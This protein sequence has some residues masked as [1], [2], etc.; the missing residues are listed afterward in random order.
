MEARRLTEDVE[1]GSSSSDSDDEVL[2][3]TQ[4]SEALQRASRVVLGAAALTALLVSAAIA[5]RQL[6]G[7]QEAQAAFDAASQLV[8][9]KAGGFKRS[10]PWHPKNPLARL[11][12]LHDGNLCEDDE[13]LFEGLCYKKCSLLT[14][15]AENVRLSAFSCGQSRSM[16]DLLKSEVNTFEPCHGYDI[17]G[18]DAG[19]GCPHS[20]GACLTDEEFSLGKCYKKCSL[21]TSGQYPHRTSAETCCKSK[22]LVQCLWPSNSKFSSDFSVGGG[23]GAESIAHNPE[24]KYTEA[25]GA[26]AV[27]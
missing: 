8:E 3:L 21:L 14:G 26:T 7:R 13:E 10:Q 12:R 20:P 25:E 22:N 5:G 1:L 18:D 16:T 19:N 24:T 9:E 6:V 4:A 17:A 2:W 23:S 27:V 11:E 15:G